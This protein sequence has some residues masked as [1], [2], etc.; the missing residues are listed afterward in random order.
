[1]R[2]TMS[3]RTSVPDLPGAICIF[4]Q[5]YRP[6]L[7]RLGQRSVAMVRSQWIAAVEVRMYR[8]EVRIRGPL[9][10]RLNALKRNLDRWPRFRGPRPPSAGKIE[11][12]YKDGVLTV[13][14]PKTDEAK[15]KHVEI[16]VH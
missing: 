2:R 11:A 16:K 4:R 13:T 3:A 12:P 9:W 6:D 14:C 1:M 7:R 15:R 5:G 10:D 8:K